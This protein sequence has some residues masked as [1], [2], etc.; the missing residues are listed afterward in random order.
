MGKAAADVLRLKNEA[1]AKGA[2][3]LVDA[4]GDP[5]SYNAYIFA[6]NFEPT[7]LRLIFAGP[8]TFWTDLKTFEQV[9]ATRLFSEPGAETSSSITNP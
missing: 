7:E 4:F 9:G 2:K 8:G 6:K 5:Q 3:M 1:E